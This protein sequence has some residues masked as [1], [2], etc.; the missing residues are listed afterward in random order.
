MSK[1]LKKQ[2]YAAIGCESCQSTSVYEG[3]AISVEDAFKK[4]EEKHLSDNTSCNESLDRTGLFRISLEGPGVES[5]PKTG[6]K[7]RKPTKGEQLLESIF[8]EMHG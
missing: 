4:A 5:L 7:V 2:V 1:K 6:F 3:Y 8:K